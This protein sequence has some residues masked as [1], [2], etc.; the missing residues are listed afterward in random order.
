MAKKELWIFM[1]RSYSG[2][3]QRKVAFRASPD[4]LPGDIGEANDLGECLV[5]VVY[6]SE[7]VL[8]SILADDLQILSTV[9]LQFIWYMLVHNAILLYKPLYIVVVERP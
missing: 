4:Y 3:P 7:D 1:V 2:I 6:L 9:P 5:S 8:F